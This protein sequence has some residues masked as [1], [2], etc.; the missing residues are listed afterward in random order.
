MTCHVSK[1]KLI[2]IRV[3]FLAFETFYGWLTVVIVCQ[4]PYGQTWLLEHPLFRTWLLEHPFI[5]YL[6]VRASLYSVPGR[7]SSPISQF[8]VVR[9]SQ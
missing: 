2:H 5:P 7:W 1:A 6:V 3:V 4:H 9:A 8:L